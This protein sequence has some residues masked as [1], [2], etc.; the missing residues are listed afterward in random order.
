MEIEQKKRNNST[1]S[2]ADCCLRLNDLGR[3]FE[4][5]SDDDLDSL[6]AVAFGRWAYHL[7]R[8]GYIKALYEYRKNK[9]ELYER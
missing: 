3:A 7:T 2:Y 9:T 4:A 1:L 8:D 5:M 6:Y